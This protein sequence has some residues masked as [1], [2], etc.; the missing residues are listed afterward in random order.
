MATRNTLEDALAYPCVPRHQPSKLDASAS[1]GLPAAGVL[2]TK[3]TKKARDDLRIA[4]NK[5]QT[6][7]DRLSDVRRTTSEE[8][9]TRIFP[10]T[11]AP[12]VGAPP[13]ER[14]V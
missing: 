14:A 7:I 11:Y 10:M 12:V 4:T 6:Y 2:Q 8:H 9:D 1:E 13:V 5:I 3:E